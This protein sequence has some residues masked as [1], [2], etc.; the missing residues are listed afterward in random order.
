MLQHVFIIHSHTT[1]LTSMGVLDF[2]KANKKDIVFLYSRHYNNSLINPECK[3]IDITD[4]T[5]KQDQLWNNKKRNS[6]IKEIDR[7]IDNVVKDNFIL[8][9]PHF[10]M[11]F[12]QVL[13]THKKC[14][15]AAYI[16]EGGM[17]Y[18]KAFITHLSFLK[19]I[20]YFI[21]DKLYRRTNRLWSTYGWYMSG[22]LYKQKDLDSYAISDDV[23]K[24]LPS[25]NHLIKWPR[26]EV[27]LV[28]KNNANIFVFDGFVKNGLIEQGF[29][30]NNCKRLIRKF[31]QQD[32]YIKFHPAQ[33]QEECNTIKSYFDQQGCKYE[34]LD[35]SV[36]FEIILSSKTNLSVIGFGSSLLYF[37]RDLGHTVY[38]MDKW[39]E[40]SSLYLQYKTRYGLDDF[41][42]AKL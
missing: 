36:P 6:L 18:R 20:R 7:L 4:L 30:L 41:Q 9:T 13:Y 5:D 33:S 15:K 31:A 34:V 37:A 42:K 38:C 19:R 17:T 35:N 22:S 39:L 16:Q 29:Y 26:I 32:N 28:L 23:F 24:Y 8:Y 11:P 40:D 14:T 1:F 27:P 2:I 12:A 3:T 25:T 10:A 21:I